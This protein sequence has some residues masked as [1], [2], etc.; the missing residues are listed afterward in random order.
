MC[1]KWNHNGNWLT[2][3]A[4]D[5]LIKI[6]DIRRD[7]NSKWFAH[8]EV[9]LGEGGREVCNGLVGCVGGWKVAADGASISEAATCISS[10]IGIDYLLVCMF[11]VRVC[12]CYT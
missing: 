6:F 7:F 3:A 4:R 1:V 2:S 5:H 9:H 11:C 10:A 12:V 8:Y